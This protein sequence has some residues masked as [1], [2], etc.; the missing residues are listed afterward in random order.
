MRQPCT[1][2]CLL[3]IFVFA[4]YYFSPAQAL[5]NDG[6]TFNVA[7]SPL[8]VIDDERP[9][10]SSNHSTY[11]R[12]TNLSDGAILSSFTHYIGKNTRSLSVSYSTDGG[13][14]FSDFSEVTQAEGDVDNMFLLEV[15]KDVVL[16]SFRNHD[17]EYFRITI[18]RSIDGGRTW[19]F[20]SQAAEKSGSLGLWEPFMRLGDEGE[21]QLTFS[22]EFAHNTQRTMRVVSRDQGS[23]WSTPTCLS[24][25]KKELRDGMNGI[26]KT[27]DNGR[28]ALVMV[29][30]TNRYGTY[31][32][33]SLVSYDDGSTWSHRG[34]IFRPKSG[35][36]AG[37]PQIASFG[38]GSMVTVFMT[39][40]DADNVDWPKHASI[41]AV[42][43][44]PPKNGTLIWSDPTLISS[45]SSFWPGL[46]SINDNTAL[47]T[48][49]RGAKPLV[50]TI[51]WNPRVA[52]FRLDTYTLRKF[53]RLAKEAR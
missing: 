33:E 38:D 5:N 40:E 12:L 37:S 29:I 16:A 9:V 44:S 4:F 50:K 21:V 26:T 6:I 14:T 19:K 45:E 10:S 18:C 35:H 13:K 39:D 41:K 15:S 25:C 48:Y 51:K 36:N 22:Q 52:G 31:N 27:N 47:V 42:F 20:V 3:S 34:C 7:T 46:L 8:I 17:D 43:A 32:V 1:C 28:D 11:P 49:D 23:T 24:G 53:R 2:L 30:E